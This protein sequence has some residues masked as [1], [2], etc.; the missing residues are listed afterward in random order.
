M[1][2]R[3]P[4]KVRCGDPARERM[5]GDCRR[6]TSRRTGRRR[7]ANQD[8]QVR[9]SHGGS[10]CAQAT[11]VTL[12]GSRPTSYPGPRLRH[13]FHRRAKAGL[14]I[15]QLVIDQPAGTMAR[16]VGLDL[17]HRA[18][19]A[20]LQGEGPRIKD[21]G[22]LSEARCRVFYPNPKTGGGA[23]WNYL[24]G[25]A[26]ALKQPGCAT[27]EIL[28]GQGLLAESST[29]SVPV[30]GF[31]RAGRHHHLRP[32]QEDRRRPPQLGGTRRS[33]CSRR[34]GSDDVEPVTLE[35]LRSCAS[36]RSPV[37]DREVDQKRHRARSPR[38][39]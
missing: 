31:R 14:L 11:S 38:P 30:L 1:A 8:L 19:G 18:P 7:A 13:R 22:D 17:D 4:S 33:W 23:R 5:S 25:Y 26:W 35:L 39:I 37:V 9:Q 16:C 6:R 27:P 21:W 24:G 32:A 34:W 29:R 3:N 12:A 2:S 15:R 36:P 28:V 20:G 10:G